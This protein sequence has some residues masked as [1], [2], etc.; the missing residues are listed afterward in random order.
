VAREF[1]VG[2]G[3]VLDVLS[4]RDNGRLI[5]FNPATGESRVL[6]SNLSYANGVAL[7][8]DESYLLVADQLRY[9]ILRYWLTGP[10]AGTHDVWSDRLPGLP[11]NIT[12]DDQGVLWVALTQNR[13][14]L[15]HDNA[16]LMAQLAKLPDALIAPPA[17]PAAERDPNRRGVGSVIALDLQGN[18][19]LSLQ[20]PP[21]A[22]DTLST[23]VYHDG[24]V[25]LGSLGGGPVFRVPLPERPLPQ[26]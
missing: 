4:G 9:R 20:N 12:L 22:L 2:I 25:Y 16:W 23:A 3:E 19:L 7:A 21:L 14:G 15:P 24:F 17:V 5:E 10:Q 6:L 1:S 13:P 18:P 8:P 11:H 26:P